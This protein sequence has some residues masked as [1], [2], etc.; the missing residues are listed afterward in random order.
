[1][2]YDFSKEK[3]H[4]GWRPFDME[5]LY[6]PTVEKKGRFDPL[7]FM[8]HQVETFGIGGM[9]VVAA[10]YNADGFFEDCYYSI[11]SVPQHG[12]FSIGEILH[13]L[14]EHDCLPIPL[15]PFIDDKHKYKN[16]IYMLMFKKSQDINYLRLTFPDLKYHS[17][18][19]LL[20][21][22]KSF[23]TTKPPFSNW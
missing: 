1:M 18:R 23:E 3:S 20:D 17:G 7:N 6:L 13:Q 21:H 12:P 4:A 15:I 9:S 16:N 11:H 8:F 14:N 22:L 5:F 19:E 10:W 2:T